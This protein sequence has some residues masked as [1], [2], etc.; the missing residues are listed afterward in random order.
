MDPKFNEATY[1]RPEGDRVIDAPFLFIDIEKY[2]RQILE[3]EAWQK[4]DRNGITLFKSEGS[5]IVLTALHAGADVPENDIKGTVFIQVLEGLVAL[6]LAG[7]KIELRKGNMVTLH[8]NIKHALFATDDSLLL[9][10]T[11]MQN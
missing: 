3:E 4:N 1:N 11:N 10:T 5:T 8:A 2:H 9:I 6:D 7:E